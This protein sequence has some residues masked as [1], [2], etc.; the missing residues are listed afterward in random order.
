MLLASLKKTFKIEG[1]V[2]VNEFD[3]VSQ[4][5][6][7]QVEYRILAKYIVDHETKKDFSLTFLSL[8]KNRDNSI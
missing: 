5:Y 7:L 3:S 1:S 4:P 8:T 2:N 6:A